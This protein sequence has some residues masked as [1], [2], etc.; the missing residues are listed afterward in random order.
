MVALIFSVFAFVVSLQ[1]QHPGSQATPT[2]TAPQT[3]VTTTPGSETTPAPTQGV[4]QAPTPI[5]SPA[6][7]DGI[8]STAGTNGKVESVS[9]AHIVGNSSLQALVTVRH[10]DANSSLDVYVFDRITSVNPTQLFNLS[11]L[12]NGEVKISG[13]SSVLT[14][15]VDPNSALNTG[16]P[17]VQWTADLF[18]EFA[19][20]G[21]SLSQ[22]AFPDLTRYQAEADQASIN[23]GHQPW[24]NDAV[25]IAKALEARFFD[26]QRPVT[27]KLLSGGGPHDVSATVQVQ[28]ASVQGSTPTIVV[29]LSRLEGNTHNMWVATGVADGSTL[30]LKNIQPRQL[31]TSPVTLEGTGVAFEAVIGHAVVY[32]HLYSDTGHAQITG[33][34]GMGM[35]TYTTPVSYATSFTGIQEGMVAVYANNGGLSAEN[36]TAVI[37]KV[38][39]SPA[40]QALTV[41]SVN[42]AVS[43]N[44]IAGINCGSAMTLTYTATFHVQSGK[45]GGTIRFLYTWNNG[46]SSPVGSVTVPPNGPNTVTFTYTATGQVGGAYAF[47]GVAQVNVTSPNTV[48]SNQVMPTGTCT[49]SSQPTADSAPAL[50]PFNGTPYVS[51]TS[52]NAAHNLSLATYDTATKAF[53]PVTVLTDTTLAGSGPSLEVFNGNLYMAWLGT[54][55]HLNVARYNP[56][57]PTQLAGKVTLSETSN[58]APSLAAFNGR[59]YLSWRGTDGRLNIISSADARTFDTKVTYNIAIRTSPAVGAADNALFIAWGD[60]SASSFI[61]VGTYQPS[62]PTN[63]TMVTTTS[64]SQLP[65]GLSSVG[66]PAPYIEIAWRTA[67]DTHIHLGTFEGT[68]AI[69][70]QVITAQTTPYSLTLANIGGTRYLCWTGTDTAQTINV[71]PINT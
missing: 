56:A 17:V 7:W 25:Q 40:Q 57:S 9:F 31:I 20:N 55:G 44:S 60:T 43:P 52:M 12:I 70:N 26:W 6:Y 37:M 54:D 18:R 30:T 24:K 41:S 50:A 35:G 64:T 15:Q 34:N 66:V 23:Q 28:E 61:V 19:W 1:G 62:Q 69:Q 29:T 53:G 38:M 10:S 33:S 46:R 59:L 36:A 58:N 39:L 8:L 65:V 4:T 21:S 13:Y 67:S 42:L 32:D 22:V 63:L 14:A 16:K 48:Q 3:T 68:P 45:S 47:P 71:S 11:A 49:V 51:W 5:S 2:P 27:A